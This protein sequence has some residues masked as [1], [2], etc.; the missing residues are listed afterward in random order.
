M[1]MS[2]V[3]LGKLPHREPFLF[4]TSLDTLEAG[5]RGTGTWQVRGDEGFF[6]GHFPGNPVLPGVLLAE[7]LAQLSGLVAFA[8]EDGG[9]AVSA[10]L[11]QVDV[12][13]RSA[14]VPPALV[15]LESVIARE[16]SGLFLFDVRAEVQGSVVAQGSLVLATSS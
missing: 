12:K 10:R 14:V 2:Q 11:A 8:S 15:R 9:P 4:L 3:T 6:S 1:A 5:R 13:F 16:M 7:S